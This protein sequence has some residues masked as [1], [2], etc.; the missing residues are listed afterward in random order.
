MNNHY[1][2]AR[3]DHGNAAKAQKYIEHDKYK[4]SLL[5]SVT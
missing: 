4:N 2:Q 3:T 1:Q 5:K